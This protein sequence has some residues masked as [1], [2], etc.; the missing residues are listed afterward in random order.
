M[1]IKTI[2]LTLFLLGGTQVIANHPPQWGSQYQCVARE[3]GH[4]EHF[5]GHRSIGECLRYHDECYETCGYFGFEPPAYRNLAYEDCLHRGYGFEHCNRLFGRRVWF[6]DYVSPVY[7]RGHWDSYRNYHDRDRW[8]RILE[9][10]RE[11]ERRWQYDRGHHDHDSRR[12]YRHGRDDR[13]GGDRND[14]RDSDRRGDD[15]R[16]DRRESDR[17]RRGR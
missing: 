13:R 1:N 15:R 3:T 17:G 6:Q 14:R 10:R 5:T 9:R 4:E 16:D 7:R 2:F 11:R 12:D 8:D